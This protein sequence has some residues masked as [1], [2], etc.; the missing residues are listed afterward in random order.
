MP[1]VKL[2]R[3]YLK[4]KKDD[5][6]NFKSVSLIF[7]LDHVMKRLVRDARMVA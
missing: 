4:N 7:I 3:Q 5:L 6:G 2:L 1:E